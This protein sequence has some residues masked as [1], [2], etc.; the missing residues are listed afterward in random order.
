MILLIQVSI[1]KSATAID[2][3]AAKEKP[4][5]AGKRRLA[6]H[7]TGNAGAFLSIR[8]KSVLRFSGNPMLEQKN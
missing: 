4:P 5:Q 8:P 3:A 7:L 6:R 2:C 1:R